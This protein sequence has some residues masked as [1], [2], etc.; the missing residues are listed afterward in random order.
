MMRL[1]AA[2]RHRRRALTVIGS[3]LCAMLYRLAQKTLRKGSNEWRKE[4][5]AKRRQRMLAA[6]VAAEAATDR[7]AEVN[8]AAAEV[9]GMATPV[10]VDSEV[11]VTM[12]GDEPVTDDSA[13]ASTAG[14]EASKAS[15]SADAAAAAA[16][17]TIVKDEKHINY[18]I[19]IALCCLWVF[20]FVVAFLRGGTVR[21]RQPKP[22]HQTEGW[23]SGCCKSAC[24]MH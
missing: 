23:S 17:A 18:K 5:E 10:E 7:G 15:N 22:K 19:L 8:A 6:A 16:L 20:L 2:R 13:A 21:S 4:M 11:V 14:V 3:S 9:V 1:V 24:Q 12:L